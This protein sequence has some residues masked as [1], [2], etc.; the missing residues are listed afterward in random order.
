MNKYTLGKKKSLSSRSKEQNDKLS[1]PL[2][3]DLSTNEQMLKAEFHNNADVTF[4]PFQI[5]HQT[6]ALLVY[7]STLCD[8]EQLD[9]L[10]LAPLLNRY[11][12]NLPVHVS[13]LRNVIPLSKTQ[14]ILSLHQAVTAINIGLPLLLIDGSDTA[15]SYGLQKYEQ[16]SIEEP[17]AESTVRGP[18]DG[19]TESISVNISLIRKRLKNHKL[20]LLN[21]EI[22]TV[23]KTNIG[24]VYLDGIMDPAILEEAK[25]RLASIETDS[26]LESSYVEEW[27]SDEPLSPFPQLLSTERP[28]VV[29]ANLLEGRFAVIVDGTPFVLIAP[30]NLFSMLQSPEDYYQHIWMS[31]FVRWLRYVFF[32]L[33]L[34]LPSFYIAITTYHQEMIP[35]VLLLSIAKAR[36]EIPFPAL[37]EALIMEIAFEALREAGIRLPKQVGAAVSIVGALIIGQAATSAGIVSAPMVIVVA[38]TGIASFMIP[39]YSAGIASRLLRFPIMLLAG[40]LGLIGLMLGMIVLVIHLCALRSF[41]IPYLSPLSPSSSKLLT[42]VLSRA[43]AWKTNRN[44]VGSTRRR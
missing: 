21:M 22:G 13:R 34:L 35:T 41:G 11:P 33:S 6:D 37:V 10:V 29:C 14:D 7:L 18:R 42:D 32:L 36:E 31:T 30:I 5:N 20:K 1:T 25:R 9:H 16:R 39:R 40:V 38:T 28:D 43:P 26:I 4:H 27:I 15:V 3:S 2:S 17:S 44:K 19:F 12:D 8:T 24:L 23:T